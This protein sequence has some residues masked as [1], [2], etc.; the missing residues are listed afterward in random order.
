MQLPA[1]HLYAAAI[2]LCLFAGGQARAELINWSYNWTVSPKQ[3]NADV[4][5]MGYITL[6]ASAGTATGD[7]FIVATNM[8]TVSNASPSNPATFTNAKYSLTLSIT[9]GDSNTSGNLS[10]NGEFNG[11]LSKKGPIL[12]NDF[13]GQTTQSVT[14]GYHLYTVQ[15]GP[16]APPFPP[17]QDPGSI[18]ISALASVTVSDAPEPSTLLLSGMCVSLCGASW[19]WKRRRDRDRL[20]EHLSSAG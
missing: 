10:F 13:L 2:A 12:L 14:I 17:P 6:T 11:I 15:I 20:C 18:S 4:P 19:W 16:F 7:S 3:A 9:D 5:S 1:R 8:Q